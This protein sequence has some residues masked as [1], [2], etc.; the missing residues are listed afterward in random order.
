MK[1]REQIYEDYLSKYS[2][3]HC[4]LIKKYR[5]VFH[6]VSVLRDKEEAIYRKD[7]TIAKQLLHSQ[8]LKAI[9]PRTALSGFYMSVQK[10]QAQLHTHPKNIHVFS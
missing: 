3:H 6:Y 4:T 8:P 10:H 7:T 1:L 5:T 2:D 9:L